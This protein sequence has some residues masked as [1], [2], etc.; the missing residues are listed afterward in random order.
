MTYEEKKIRA[1]GCRLSV[2]SYL[3]NIPALAQSAQ[4]IHRFLAREHD[5]TLEEV[6]DS[7]LFLS[8]DSPPLVRQVKNPFG[9]SI[10]YQISTAGVRAAEQYL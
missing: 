3:Y 2:L 5:W 4:T 6:E 7:L 9:A 8:G 10:C 1:E